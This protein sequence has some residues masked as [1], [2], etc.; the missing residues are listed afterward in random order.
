M[1]AVYHVLSAQFQ[2][3]VQ[4]IGRRFDRVGGRL[5]Q[6]DDVCRVR[7]VQIER[8][9]QKHQGNDSRGNAIRL[10]RISWNQSR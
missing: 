3:T 8:C 2:R 10:V 7:G 4:Q 6:S 9:D 5:K 1:P